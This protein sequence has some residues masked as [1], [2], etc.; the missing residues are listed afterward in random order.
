MITSIQKVHSLSSPA[1]ITKLLGVVERAREIVPFYQEHYV[2]IDFSTSHLRVSDLP[3]LDKSL[4]RMVGSKITRSN[5]YDN[6][7]GIGIGCTS[8]STGIPLHLSRTKAEIAQWARA[9]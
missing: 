4:V 9:F 8:G 6:Q 5:Y 7:P 1:A 2:Q 3:L